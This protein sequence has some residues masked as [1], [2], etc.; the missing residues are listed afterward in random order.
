MG[1][2]SLHEGLEVSTHDLPPIVGLTGGIGS[3]KSTVANMFR[4]LGI[5]VIDADRLARDVVAPG[6]DG[7]SQI[8]DHFGDDVLTQDGAL[9]R[10]KL[11]SIVFDDPDK[12]RELER[13]THPL[14]GAAMMQRAAEAG[15]SG[16]PWVIYDAA[17]LV[18]N[19]LEDAFH[20]LIVVALDRDT[21]MQRVMARDGLDPDDVAK[22]ID[23]QMPLEEKVA[24]A[25]IVIDNGGTLEETKQ[26][27]V[28]AKE[29]IDASVASNEAN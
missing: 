5:T 24:V 13:I 2:R 11:G 27:V 1:L 3:G 26:Q 10:A 22:R 19:G 16:E 21:Q 14:I 29:A 7:L 17:L 28:A 6:S 4:D 9:D 18:E 25:D 23:A 8:V 20:R 12:R 15:Q